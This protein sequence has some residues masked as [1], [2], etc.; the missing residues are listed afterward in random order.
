MSGGGE[1]EGGSGGGGEEGRGGG[2]EL[3][4]DRGFGEWP[5]GLLVTDDVELVLGVTRGGVGEGLE[6]LVIGMGV[7]KRLIEGEEALRGEAEGVERR[8]GG[9]G[10]GVGGSR[11]LLSSE[12]SFSDG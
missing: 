8:E 9:V 5:F 6:F 11:S 3:G 4:R 1:W 12:L 2:G 7:E 10:D